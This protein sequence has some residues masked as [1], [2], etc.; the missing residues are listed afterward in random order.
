MSIYQYPWYEIVNEREGLEQG[1]FIRSWPVIIPEEMIEGEGEIDSNVL[2]RDM[3]IMSQSCD[4]ANNKI[5]N[6][7]VCPVLDLETMTKYA[8]RGDRNKLRKGEII[9][10][11]LLNKCTLIGVGN[12]CG[13]LEL[14]GKYP[15][16]DFRNAYSIPLIFLLKGIESRNEKR[17]RLLPPY[18]EQLS[19]AF[20]RFIMRVGLQD[21]C[22]IP[23]F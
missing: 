5:D 6:V 17:L 1:D 3:I 2:E 18:K 4:I 14:E 13:L 16:V 23:E 11:H 22:D 9:G 15:V 20:A 10:Y 21:A 7:L 12:E 19:Q 8:G